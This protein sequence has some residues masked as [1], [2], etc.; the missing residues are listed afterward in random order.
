M[1][2][3]THLSA[4]VLA[5]AGMSTFAELVTARSSSVAL[6]AR[7][8]HIQTSQGDKICI[9]FSGGDFH[10]RNAGSW[11][12]THGQGAQSASQCFDLVPGGAMFICENECDPAGDAAAAKYT[13][14]E[15]TFGGMYENC[16]MSIVDGFSL[17]VQC[18]IPGANPPRIGGLRDLSELAP[19]RD[20]HPDN[21][22]RNT[23]AYEPNESAVDQYF[24]NANGGDGGNYCVY[25]YC[26]KDSDSFFTGTPTITCEVASRS[27]TSKRRDLEAPAVNASALNRR[28]VA[29]E[30]APLLESREG[31]HKTHYHAH[32]VHAHAHA[33]SLKNILV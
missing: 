28:Q 23:G 20:P 14:L 19:C 3:T 5:L 11:G 24:Q 22:C 15:C 1:K 25:Q 10:W 17:P 4:A 26:S 12:D 31:A 27:S 7:E 21:T 2:H 30:M 6:P 33:R 13:K 9:N 18:D 29:R 8:E 32:H 16:D